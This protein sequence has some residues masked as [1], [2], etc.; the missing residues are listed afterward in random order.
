MTIRLL[1]TEEFADLA[2]TSPNT[3]RYWRHTKKG[4]QG[5]RRGRR[6]LYR[7]DECERWLAEEDEPRAGDVA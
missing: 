5:I 7:A 3:I 1:T 6:V 4:P 2:H